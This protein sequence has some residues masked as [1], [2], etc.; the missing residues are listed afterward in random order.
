MHSDS[1]TTP[2]IESIQVQNSVLVLSG[3]GLDVRVRHG[4]LCVKDGIADKRREA[5]FNK[6]TC[7]IERL[8]GL[9]HS[10]TISLEA[11]RWLHDIRAAVIQIDA[12]GQVILTSS[13]L[14]TNLPHLR[15]AQVSAFQGDAG[16]RITKE[17]LRDKLEGQA[18]LAGMLGGHQD[19]EEIHSLAIG[20][21]EIGDIPSLRLIE[22]QAARKYWGLWSDV[23]VNFVRS[24]A[25][26]V[27][28]YWRRFDQRISYLTGTQR[29]A[30][31]P[32]N[33]LLNYLYAILETEARIALLTVGLDPGLG[34][35]H[36]DQPNRDSLALDVMEAVRPE[37][38]ALLYEFLQNSHFRRR[39][40][41]ARRDGT[42]RVTSKLTP[43]LAFT[44]PIWADGVARY[45]EWVAHEL[46]S[47]ESK[48]KRKRKMATPL[49]QANRSRGRANVHPGKKNKKGVSN[50]GKTRTCRECG[51]I[52][53]AN[54]VF[55]SDECY[56][57]YNQEVLLPRFEKSGLVKLTELRAEGNDPAHGGE[58]GRKRG[59]TNSEWAKKRKNWEAVHGN[60]YQERGRFVKEILPALKEIPLTKIMAATGLS[61][62][63][64]SMIRRGLDI[65]HPMHN[66]SLERLT[67]PNDHEK[68]G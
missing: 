44:A 38:D 55:C 28:K 53:R 68:V 52:I 46:D 18:R 6:A 35:F 24:E 61:K 47:G 62:R 36:V 17:L 45:C 22:S 37:V 7:K 19:S 5:R 14:G 48:S 16:L 9:G 66:E 32:A 51:K 23:Q 26:K 54:R 39:H 29:K 2:P 1:S 43:A 42:V 49:T 13:P 30:S 34:L 67:N 41:F 50:I 63:Y 57:I 58:V 10:G 3:Y 64:A 27:P 56:E 25:G 11:L 59:R 12:D 40:F 20:L 15:R 31:N 21:D 65:P 4:R 60:G 33:A 8:V